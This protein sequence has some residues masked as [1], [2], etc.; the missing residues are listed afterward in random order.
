M[1]KV[2][3]IFALIGVTIPLIGIVAAIRNREPDRWAEGLLIGMYLGALGCMSLIAILV[4][5]GI[6]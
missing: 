4:Q 1:A 5:F 2:Q 3:F 6:L